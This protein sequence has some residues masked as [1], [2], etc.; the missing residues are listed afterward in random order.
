MKIVID[1]DVIK[2]N[3]YNLLDVLS[4]LI[5]VCCKA[6]P[7]NAVQS[8][9]RKLCISENLLGEYNL[10]DKQ[11]KQLQEMLLTSEDINTDDETINLANEMRKLFPSGTKFG[12]SWRSNTSDIVSRLKSFYKR[13]GK[14]SDEE[15]LDAT[16]RY[17]ASFNCDNTNMRVLKYFIWKDVQKVDDNGRGYIERGSD[18]AS[19]IDDKNDSANNK[20]NNYGDTFF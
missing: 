3:G 12:V 16:R 20:Y 19:W 14:Y 9:C 2:K 15:I 1:E 6:N 18:L 17:V 7:V 4:M 5:V 10:P 13:Y 11:Y 8:T